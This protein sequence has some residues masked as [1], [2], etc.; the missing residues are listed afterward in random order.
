L[1]TTLLSG[2]TCI[3]LRMQG[4]LTSQSHGSYFQE[5]NSNRYTY[6][7]KC[8]SRGQSYVPTNGDFLEE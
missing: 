3:S 5:N 8:Q 6:Q 7:T 4:P 2:M 1:S